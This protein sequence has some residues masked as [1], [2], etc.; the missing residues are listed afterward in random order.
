M[1]HIDH[2]LFFSSRLPTDIYAGTGETNASNAPLM[3]APL[4]AVVALFRQNNLKSNERAPWMGFGGQSDDWQWVKVRALTGVFA[5][6]SSGGI[7]W[8]FIVAIRVVGV[9]E[10]GHYAHEAQ[11]NEDAGS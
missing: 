1:K 10:K 2:S 6:S 5:G 7:W 11:G 9:G 8:G 4:G 3:I